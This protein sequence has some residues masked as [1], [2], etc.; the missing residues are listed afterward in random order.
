[1]INK[2][3]LILFFIVQS[4]LFSS[5]NESSQIDLSKSKWEYII[6]DSPFENNIPLSKV[7][8]T[9]EFLNKIILIKNIKILNLFYYLKDKVNFFKEVIFFKLRKL[10]NIHKNNR[11]FILGNGPSLCVEDLNKIKDDITFPANKIYLAFD[12][13]SFRPKYYFVE[14]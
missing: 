11:A 4:F 2:L 13:T 10:K 3:L 1:M 5:V 7:L 8:Y 12:E 14:N 6:G 9:F